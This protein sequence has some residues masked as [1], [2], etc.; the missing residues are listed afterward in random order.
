MKDWDVIMPSTVKKFN[1]DARRKV[2][3][4]AIAQKTVF[5]EGW[6]IRFCR[7]NDTFSQ[8]FIKFSPFHETSAGACTH[9]E[10][11]DIDLF[12]SILF[13]EGARCPDID[14]VV[15]HVDMP[16]SKLLQLLRESGVRGDHDTIVRHIATGTYNIMPM[17]LDPTVLRWFFHVIA[18]MSA[19]LEDDVPETFTLTEYQ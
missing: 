14:Y 3:T 15:P 4:R 10:Q 2:L 5:C 7:S 18:E 6:E 19:W 13:H 16:E 1:D 17:S 9:F 8:C 12:L 11:D